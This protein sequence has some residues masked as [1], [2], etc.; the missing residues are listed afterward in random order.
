MLIFFDESFRNTSTNP[1]RTTGTL[2][3]IA[4]PERSLHDVVKDVY[5]LKYNHLG[6]EY[7]KDKEIKGKDLFKNYV[8]GLE[9]RGIKSKNLALAEDIIDYIASKNL[10][11]FGC[12]S[13]E[14]DSQVFKCQNVKSLD[15]TFVY[16]FERIDIFMKQEKSTSL[17]KIIFDD[18]GYSIN[19][20]NSEA[21]T[22][23][24]VRSPQGLAMDSILKVPLFAISEAQ[25]IG[26]QLAD[27][28]TSIIS[29][30]FTGEK[31]IDKFW[32]RL[33]PCIYRW[34]HNSKIT[35]TSLKII[36]AK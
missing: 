5:Q 18:R 33:K 34:Q 30:R 21:I 20:Q 14:Q 23:F 15:K 1:V 28:V 29:L 7:A 25:N 35:N 10:I 27:F 4:I 31:R 17:A 8:F 2:C 19:C 6:E 36:K 3:G 9:D 13:F 16:L 32:K 12:V 24:F 22:N 26:L 11:V